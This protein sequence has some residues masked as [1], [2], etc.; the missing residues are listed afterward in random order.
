MA[1]LAPLVVGIVA[2]GAGV[3]AYL[4]NKND[5]AATQTAAPS[6]SPPAVAAAS[7]APDVSESQAEVV[8]KAVGEAA[9]ESPAVEK[10][11]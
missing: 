3:W 10:E 1:F 9:D 6:V 4:R 7:A 2:G 11:D 8:V 5:G